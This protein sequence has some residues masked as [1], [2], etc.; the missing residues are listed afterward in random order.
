M[1]IF[2]WLSLFDSSS[3]LES[4]CQDLQFI[5][6][7]V[8]AVTICLESLSIPTDCLIPTG[9]HHKHKQD[10][11]HPYVWY[12]RVSG[13]G[14]ALLTVHFSA[15]IR[16]GVEFTRH[17]GLCFVCG[18]SNIEEELFSFSNTNCWKI[19][20]HWHVSR[21]RV[22]CLCTNDIEIHSNGLMSFNLYHAFEYK[23]TDLTVCYHMRSRILWD[24]FSCL[25]S[26]L[27]LQV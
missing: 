22:V 14:L 26:R 3:C 24:C 23:H 13:N 25:V 17:P 20:L 19:S 18:G 21:L 7:D 12:L 16:W 15:S 5:C 1:G 10:N 27:Y 4:S 2:R 8:S 11:V 6:L 9:T